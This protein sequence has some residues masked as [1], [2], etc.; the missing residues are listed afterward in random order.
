MLDACLDKSVTSE[1]YY[2]SHLVKTSDPKD[3]QVVGFNRARIS[4]FKG[5]GRDR[6]FT[7]VTEFVLLLVLGI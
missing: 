5:V 1:E 2:K 7:C 3:Y 4:N 6:S